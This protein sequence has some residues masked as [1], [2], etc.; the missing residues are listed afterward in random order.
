MLITSKKYLFSL[1]LALSLTAC[2]STPANIQRYNLPESSSTAL[3]PSA[4][5]EQILVI[6]SIHLAEFLDN[7]SIVLQLDDIT[8]HQAREHLWAENL[9]Q[10]LRRGLRSRLAAQ[11][12]DML[13]VA[14]Q[15]GIAQNNW[16]L[17]LDIEKFQ[18][19]AAG[20]ALTSGQ[21][22]LHNAQGKLV[23]IAPFSLETPLSSDGYPA[24]VRA[25]GTNL[26]QLAQQLA[27]Q[28]QQQY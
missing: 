18:G 3:I 27:R 9:S 7:E 6:G 2:A 22:Q 21:W 16:N 10:Q 12:P 20:T 17:Q 4:N 5:A 26:D 11:L 15:H 23:F 24:L 14:D 28:I 25:L 1:L 8:L 13:V 19:H